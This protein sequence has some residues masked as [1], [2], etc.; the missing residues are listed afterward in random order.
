MIG[1]I[2]NAMLGRLRAASQ[3][4]ALGYTIPLLGSYQ[5]DL[6][7]EEALARLAPQLPAV[8]AIYAGDRSEPM[9]LSW[10]YHCA[11]SLF[12]VVGNLRNEPARRLGG[13]PGEVGSYRLLADVRTL[14]AG[15][16]F[17]LPVAP[18]AIEG[19]RSIYQGAVH[20][21][22]QISVYALDVR[23][24]YSQSALPETW[25]SDTSPHFGVVELP[26]RP[27]APALSRGTA[28]GLADWTE[29]DNTWSA[30]GPAASDKVDMPS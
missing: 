14:L 21:R 25:P 18:L 13:A 5:G 9:G 20:A 23:V 3:S 12:V 7:T 19:T 2:E 17:G 22:Q 27:G 30:P 6:D 11:W 28:L 1:A 24:A 26:P 29:L 10:R 8:L 15:Q 16:T 4:G